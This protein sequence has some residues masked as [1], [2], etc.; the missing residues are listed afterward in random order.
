MSIELI[1]FGVVALVFVL[2]FVL[3]GI[4]RKKTQGGVERIGEE[5]KSKSKFP[6]SLDYFIKR[7]R[8]IVSFLIFVHPIKIFLHYYFFTGTTTRVGV[9]PPGS[10]DDFYYSG[11]YEMDLKWHIENIY[12]FSRN[13]NISSGEV[14][15]FIPSFVILGVFVWLINDKIKAR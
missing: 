4:K 2:D 8:N 1:L 13:F 9:T 3:K 12:V 10:D 7:K 6:F 14:W 15:L 5:L 11:S